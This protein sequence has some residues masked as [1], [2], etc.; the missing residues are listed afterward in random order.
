MNKQ[1][2]VL[3]GGSLITP[4]ILEKVLSGLEAHGIQAI[5]PD[6]SL[7]CVKGAVLAGLQRHGRF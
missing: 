2:S 4:Y 5:Q 7:T 1:G 3:V 6:I